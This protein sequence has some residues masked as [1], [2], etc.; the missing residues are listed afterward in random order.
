MQADELRCL[1]GSCLFSVQHEQAG[2]ALP[3]MFRVN[4]ERCDISREP[5]MTAVECKCDETCQF[6][7]GFGKNR[8]GSGS[9]EV[10]LE[11]YALEGKGCGEAEEIKLKQGL[12]IAGYCAAEMPALP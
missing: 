8:Y 1:C 11:V 3:T 5:T 2:Q 7:A 9:G 12:S 4:V 6:C 10:T